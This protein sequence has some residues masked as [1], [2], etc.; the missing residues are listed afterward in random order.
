MKPLIAEL[1]LKAFT[2]SLLGIVDESQ[3]KSTFWRLV[4]AIKTFVL[5]VELKNSVTVAIET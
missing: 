5:C 1:S 2:G 4:T 3:G